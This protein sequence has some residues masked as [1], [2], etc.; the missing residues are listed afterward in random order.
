LVIRSP[1]RRKLLKRN[2]SDFCLSIVA[3]SAISAIVG[4][5]GI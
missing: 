2:S 1:R 3:K 4:P 5:K